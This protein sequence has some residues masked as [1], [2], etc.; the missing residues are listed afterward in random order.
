MRLECTA[1]EN[2]QSENNSERV[3]KVLEFEIVLYLE[4]I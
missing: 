2:V 3:I 4:L 1:S